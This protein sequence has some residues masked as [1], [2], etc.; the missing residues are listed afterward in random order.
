MQGTYNTGIQLY[1]LESQLQVQLLIQF[2][3]GHC[4]GCQALRHT[5][6]ED[7]HNIAIV[8]LEA[9]M[10]VLQTLI[11]GRICSWLT[12]QCHTVQKTVSGGID[13]LNR[14]MLSLPVYI[15]SVPLGRHCTNNY[16]RMQNCKATASTFQ[17]Q[18]LT[19]FVKYY[20]GSSLHYIHGISIKLRVQLQ[21]Y[22]DSRYP[23]M[24]L[25]FNPK[26]QEKADHE[27]HACM[28]TVTCIKKNNYACKLDNNYNS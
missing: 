28:F 9:Y 13:D 17:A 26:R 14:Q 6:A 12:I 22:K 24:H 21:L 1:T 8:E 20:S 18:L 25:K 16:K 7:T 15:R 5:R 10:H 4:M 3:S 27:K 2:I 19:T 11:S 23:C